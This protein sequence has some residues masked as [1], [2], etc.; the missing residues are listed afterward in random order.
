[1]SGDALMSIFPTKAEN[2]NPV[3]KFTGVAERFRRLKSGNLSEN[4]DPGL[5]AKD[6]GLPGRGLTL[7]PQPPKK[8]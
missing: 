3:K 5:F 1:M 4:L 6:T 7:Q 8:G 2:F